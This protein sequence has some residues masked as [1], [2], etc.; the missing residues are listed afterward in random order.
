MYTYWPFQRKAF[1]ILLPVRGFSPP[2]HSL[3]TSGSSP[4][5]L[6]YYCALATLTPCLVLCSAKPLPML[7]CFHGHHHMAM[8]CCTPHT[9]PLRFNFMFVSLVLLPLCSKVRSHFFHPV[10]RYNKLMTFLRQSCH[11][12]TILT[13]GRFKAIHHFCYGQSSL[14]CL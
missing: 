5:W 13:K 3:A 11:F 6:C 7:P 8:P 4:P 12:S 1:T 2:P 14:C 10:L 9:A